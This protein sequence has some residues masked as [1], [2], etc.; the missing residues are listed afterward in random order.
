[1]STRSIFLSLSLLCCARFVRMLNKSSWIVR[2]I[3]YWIRLDSSCEPLG[4]YLGRAELELVRFQKNLDLTHSTNLSW[5]ITSQFIF[6]TKIYIFTYWFVR[7]FHC[8]ARTHTRGC[9]V[10]FQSSYSIIN[11]SQKDYN[12][13]CYLLGLN[14]LICLYQ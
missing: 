8:S 10:V 2:F 1:M 9:R 12:T 3:D 4:S 14:C 11:L 13:L 7:Y 6:L 5:F